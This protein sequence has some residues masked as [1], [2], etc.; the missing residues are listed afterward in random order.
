MSGIGGLDA[1]TID[2]A[3]PLTLGGF[4]AEVFGTEL[5]SVV[6]SPTQYVDL[7]PPIRADKKGWQTCYLKTDRHWNAHG[8]EVAAKAVLASAEFYRTWNVKPNA[9]PAGSGAEVISSSRAIAGVRQ[10]QRPCVIHD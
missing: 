6:G 10:D 8:N 1:I 2:C 4:W 7:L 3:D 9:T 5:G